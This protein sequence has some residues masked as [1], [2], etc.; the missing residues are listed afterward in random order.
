M[1]VV[2]TSRRR[3]QRAKVR[4]GVVKVRRIVDAGDIVRIVI[5]AGIK[6]RRTIDWQATGNRI[7]YIDYPLEKQVSV[8]KLHQN[9]IKSLH[10]E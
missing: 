9:A 10:M 2:I 1:R 3:E 7:S 5:T 4:R 6:G 8:S